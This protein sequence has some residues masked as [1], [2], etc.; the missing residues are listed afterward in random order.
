MPVLCTS[1]S[2]SLTAPKVLDPVDLS[3]LYF[4]LIFASLT[5]AA[6]LYPPLLLLP[7]NPLPTSTSL[8]PT[9]PPRICVLSYRPPSLCPAEPLHV[10]YVR[11]RRPLFPL[12]SVPP[13]CSSSR[14]GGVQRRSALWQRVAAVGPRGIRCVVFWVGV[15]IIYA[16]RL[17]SFSGFS[18]HLCLCVSVCRYTGTS[19]SVVRAAI[20]K[21]D[22][23]IF[24]RSRC[25]LR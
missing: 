13:V 11:R 4:P 14:G 20:A 8:R 22:N 3:I 2:F 21:M 12:V 10:H 7:S 16:L 19:R 5:V 6:A 15:V 23:P 24:T 25:S 18:A 9:Y 1:P 17:Q